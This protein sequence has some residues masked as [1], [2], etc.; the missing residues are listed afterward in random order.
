M[1][2]SNSYNWNPSF[3]FIATSAY[4]K[5]GVINEN[6]TPTAG[7]YQ[8]AFYCLN[9]L[10]KEWMATGIHVW[11]EEEGILFLN[12]GQVRYAIGGVTDD[13]TSDAYTYVLGTLN[14]NAAQ[15]ATSLTVESIEGILR[16]DNIGIILDD[17]STQWT[18]V[19]HTPTGTTV[20]LTDPLTDTADSGNNI[21]VYTTKLLR[22]LKISSCRL[23]LY[24]GLTETPMNMFSRK[25]Y[26]DLPN[27]NNQGTPTAFFYIPK[28]DHGELYIWPSPQNS[29]YGVRYSWYKPLMDFTDPDDTADFPQEWI[30]ALTW[31]LALELAPDF[32]VPPARFTLIAAQAAEKLD[33][34]KGWD[35]EMQPI[36]FGM[37]DPEMGRS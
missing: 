9:G 15:G 1:V 6:E 10:V 19:S 8:D 3:I 35:R 34:V 33:L 24:N 14:A 37:G 22:P 28:L 11:T 12:P 2:T 27:K 13:N 21:F 36:F 25:E 18:T 4:R 23:L 7:M 17:G 31:N 30:N 29:T 5:L 26:M 32:S 16:Y 20:R